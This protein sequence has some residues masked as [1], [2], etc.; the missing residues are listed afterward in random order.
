MLHG[1]GPEGKTAITPEFKEKW[2]YKDTNAGFDWETTQ[3]ICTQYPIVDLKWLPAPSSDPN[4]CFL[5]AIT[6]GLD[7][8]VEIGDELIV[9]EPDAFLLES[10]RD[11]I[12]SN[13]KSLKVGEGLSVK[14]V[15]FL[16]T[17]YY[18]EAINIA[19]PKYRRFCYKFDNIR[20]YQMAMDGFTSQDYNRLKKT[21]DFFVRHYCWWCP[22]EFKDL[23]YE[24]IWRKDPK[25]WQDFEKG[26]QQIR[27]ISNHIQSMEVEEIRHVELITI[28]PSRQDAGRFAQFID[29]EHPKSIES[30]PNFVKFCE[31]IEK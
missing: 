9:G 23:R 28:R 11:K 10:D 8:L 30:H 31:I 26:L 18:T 1:A 2:C 4:E 3:E 27:N 12:E 15:D 20:N 22:D 25:Y 7:D 19:N 16:E 14:Y 29:I 6:D 13:I 24:L 21:D 17:Q 5:T